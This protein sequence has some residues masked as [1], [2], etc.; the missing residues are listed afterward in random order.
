MSAAAAAATDATT[1]TVNEWTVVTA[2]NKKRVMRKRGGGKWRRASNGPPNIPDTTSGIQD[3]AV[4]ERCL[5]ECIAYLIQTCF[6]KNLVEA[7]AQNSY[8]SFNIDQIVCYGIG[9][10][11]QT[12][13][14][15][16]APSMWQLAC[17][18]AL[19]RTRHATGQEQ[20]PHCSPLPPAMR[21]YDPCANALEIQFVRQVLG[22]TI[23]EQ[24]ERGNFPVASSTPTLFFM[25]HCPARLY[26][27]VVWSNY[28]NKDG[29]D[30]WI[31]G[32]SPRQIAETNHCPCLR[33]LLDATMIVESSN[34][35][36]TRKNC[37]EAPGNLMGAFNDTYLTR[38]S[39]GRNSCADRPPRPYHQVL[40]L[41]E[42]D[43]LI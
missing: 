27:N 18:V 39:G 1:T 16:F 10:I 30:V 24:N 34:M 22:M 7:L 11:S 29:T 21:Y 5:E 38:L 3:L 25:P 23:P 2:A 4:L 36:P 32:N 15:Y 42:S 33:T 28:N 17:A 40:P 37:D 31:F 13:T 14:T 9:N 43:E 20:E 6:W 12:S 26:E 19:Q 41:E 8:N 35:E